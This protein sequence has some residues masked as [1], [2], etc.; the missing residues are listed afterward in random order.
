MGS[1]YVATHLVAEQIALLTE[2]YSNGFC[3][4]SAVRCEGSSVQEVSEQQG[5]LARRGREGRLPA[6]RA[7]AAASVADGPRQQ[8]A[9]E[10][11]SPNHL[12]HPRIGGLFPEDMMG[13]NY[14]E[15]GLTEWL[16]INDGQVG[17]GVLQLSGAVPDSPNEN[18]FPLH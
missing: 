18:S 10:H 6:P 1:I 11:R 4:K 8:R 14:G 9:A 16:L 17:L 15:W 2:P 3:C 7:G 13:R 12:L 5:R